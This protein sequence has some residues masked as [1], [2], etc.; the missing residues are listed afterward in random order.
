MNHCV[1]EKHARFA[2]RFSG[3]FGPRRGRGYP[4]RFTAVRARRE[5][6]TR[7]YAPTTSGSDIAAGMAQIA[8]HTVC[9]ECGSAGLHPELY[10]G[11]HARR[12][13]VPAIVALT[14][15]VLV[16]GTLLQV[17]GTGVVAV[18]VAVVGWQLIRDFGWQI[19]GVCPNCHCA[20]RVS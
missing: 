14:A 9:Q 4:Q 15:A 3:V 8:A 10:L 16:G 5:L 19:L 13:R 1:C 17:A 18:V 2:E 11:P 7:G 20:Q 12:W 6:R